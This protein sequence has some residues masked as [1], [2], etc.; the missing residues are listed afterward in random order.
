LIAGILI[1]LISIPGYLAMSGNLSGSAYSSPA[2]TTAAVMPDTLN[3]QPNS[4][5]EQMTYGMPIFVPDSTLTSAMPVLIPAPVDT[6]M[7]IPMAGSA[8]S[9]LSNAVQDE[10]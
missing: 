4:L 8:A 9:D 1:A 6:K 5:P 3:V 7:I 10:R 2:D